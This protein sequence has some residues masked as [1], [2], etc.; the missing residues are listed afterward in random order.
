MSTLRKPSGV[1]Q[2]AGN[3]HGS[4]P[5][6]WIADK[7]GT[8]R[9]PQGRGEDVHHSS[10]IKGRDQC[11]LGRCGKSMMSGRDDKTT[12]NLGGWGNQT[13]SHGNK[14]RGPTV[15]IQHVTTF[16][17]NH[18]R[19]STF[20]C[21]GGG[22]QL[23]PIRGEPMWGGGGAE[24]G[25]CTKQGS[26]LSF[27]PSW[28]RREIAF[29][30]GEASRLAGG[31]PPLSHGGF[32]QFPTSPAPSAWCAGSPGRQVHRPTA[33]APCVPFR[34]PDVGPVACHPAAALAHEPYRLLALRRPSGLTLF[35]SRKFSGDTFLRVI[36]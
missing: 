32:F 6:R 15:I 5:S 30:A 29:A 16:I 34:F 3:P 24:P 20:A 27:W 19:K 28:I 7:T 9:K 22:R 25:Y 2:P 33:G 18:V 21:P 14:D 17:I 10:L 11:R 13:T 8:M 1:V 36:L 23:R 12:R 26:T 4:I 35:Y 31:S